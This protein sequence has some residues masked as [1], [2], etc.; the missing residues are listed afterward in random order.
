M[1]CANC[2]TENRTEAKFCMSCGAGVAAVCPNGHPVASWA[3]FCDECGAP[4]AERPAGAAAAPAASP[5][6][7][8]APSAE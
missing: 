2:G 5:A 1:I 7:R 3:S 6:P 4:V 8:E